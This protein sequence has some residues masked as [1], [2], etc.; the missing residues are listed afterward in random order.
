MFFLVIFLFMLPFVHATDTLYPFDTVQA[1]HIFLNDIAKSRT[2]KDWTFRKF[3]SPF[4]RNVAKTNG[5][6]ADQAG[7]FLMSNCALSKERCRNCVDI[8]LVLNEAVETNNLPLKQKILSVMDQYTTPPACNPTDTHHDLLYAH[9]ITPKKYTSQESWFVP[10]VAQNLHNTA[11]IIAKLNCTHMVG[12]YFLDAYAKS[13]E[14][15]NNAYSFLRTFKQ[16]V[17]KDPNHPDIAA[18]KQAL[19]N[20]YH[21]RKAHTKK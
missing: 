6:L 10:S 13:M 8:V 2:I 5:D 4:L 11:K 7:S 16:T 1:Q 18:Y 9:S 19:G 14:D 17:D 12:A 15:G 21:T 3:A 20:W